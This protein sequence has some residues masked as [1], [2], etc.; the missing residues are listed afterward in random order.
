M[1]PGVPAVPEGP[2]A[3]GGGVALAVRQAGLGRRPA[4]M[5]LA[6][7]VGLVAA[8]DVAAPGVAVSRVRPGRRRRWRA[9]VVAVG[10]TRATAAPVVGAEQQVQLAAVV[11]RQAGQ[12]PAAPGAPVATQARPVMAEPAPPGTPSAVS[13]EPVAPEAIRAGPAQVG[14]EVRRVP[15]AADWQETWVPAAQRSLPAATADTVASA[16]TLRVI[17]TLRRETAAA[18]AVLVATAAQ[19]A[20]AG[21]VAPVGPAPA[22]MGSSS[23]AGPA[24][25]VARAVVEARSLESAAAVVLVGLAVGAGTRSPLAVPVA[26]AATGVMPVTAAPQVAAES[27]AVPVLVEPVGRAARVAQESTRPWVPRGSPAAPVVSGV[28]A[29]PPGPAGSGVTVAGAVLVALVAAV[30]PQV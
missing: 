17:P 23:V 20:T 14:P 7:M 13:V 28:L 11:F 19:S 16:T 1:R 26:R 29:V 15:V 3:L 6:A 24:A 21:S 18:T 8:A 5:V 27:P 12:A 25:R 4:Q 9:A 10:V 30:A 2:A 22:E